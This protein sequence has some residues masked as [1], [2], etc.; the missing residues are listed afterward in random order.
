MVAYR[1]PVGNSVPDF[2]GGITNTFK[3]KGFDFSV[4]LSFVSG[5][6]I[7]DDGAKFQTGGIS[8]WNQRSEILGRWQSPENPGD[9]KTP[10]LSVN[11]GG[12][13]VGGYNTTRFLYDGSFVRVRT[14]MLGYTL[15]SSILTKVRLTSARIYVSAQN[16]FT[17]T[18]YPGWD[19]EVTRAVFSR[20]EANLA[21]NAPYLPTPQA[22]QITFGVSIGF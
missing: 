7:Y 10:R 14:V 20:T 21:S 19:P 8:Q 3:F 16:L 11:Y 13:W 1:Q 22:K 4:L 9:G 2:F 5:N 15:P 18:N 6:T 12:Y 17:F